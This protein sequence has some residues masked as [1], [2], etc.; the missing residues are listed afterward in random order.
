MARSPLVR[1]RRREQGSLG[2]QFGVGLVGRRCATR[3]DSPAM[4]LL[5]PPESDAV[6][7]RLPDV[8][9]PLPSGDA[10]YEEGA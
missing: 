5:R 4:A 9:T 1:A 7:W 10:F 8:I 3:T 2:R 6:F